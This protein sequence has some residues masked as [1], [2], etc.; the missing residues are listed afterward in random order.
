MLYALKITLHPSHCTLSFQHPNFQ[1]WSE[2]AASFTFWIHIRY[3]SAVH[4]LSIS[5]SA[6][7]LLAW[8]VNGASHHKCLQFMISHLPRWLLTRRFSEETIFHPPEPPVVK[9]GVLH[10]DM[11]YCTYIH[12]GVSKKNKWINKTYKIN[13]Q[14]NQYLYI[15]R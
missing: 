10:I 13:K 12:S 6:G 4:F 7:A 5:T 1:K 14:I 8:G 11:W 15:C 2:P 3:C 9:K